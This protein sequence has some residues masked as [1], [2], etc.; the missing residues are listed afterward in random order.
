MIASYIS[1]LFA[2][3]GFITAAIAAS[4]W[5]R[6]SRK[7]GPTPQ[8]I[9]FADESMRVGLLMAAQHVSIYSAKLNSY[10][11]VWTG[12]SA[13]LCAISSV[14]GALPLSLFAS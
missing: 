7:N 9:F 6:A 14:V 5:F 3:L 2:S 4:Y 10:A 8:Q 1:I 13:L 12:I 11:A